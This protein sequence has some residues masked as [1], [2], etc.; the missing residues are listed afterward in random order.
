MTLKVYNT[1]TGKKERFLPL[2][3]GR[4]GMYVCGVTVYDDCHLGHARCYVAFDVIYRY[5]KYKG[6]KVKYVQNITDVDDKIIAKARELKKSDIRYQKSDVKAL[7]REVAERYTKEY[8]KWMDYLK[9]KRADL[10]PKA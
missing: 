7:V 6:Y 10:Y 4:V 8:F 1:L 9:I 3:K 2:K 5:L